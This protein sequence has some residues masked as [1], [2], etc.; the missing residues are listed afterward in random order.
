MNTHKPQRKLK[1][2]ISNQKSIKSLLY[3][4]ERKSN[5]QNNNNKKRSLFSKN[6]E[7]LVSEWPFFSSLFMKLHARNIAYKPEIKKDTHTS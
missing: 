7:I 4:C 2:N 3:I 1:P 5:I 6:S